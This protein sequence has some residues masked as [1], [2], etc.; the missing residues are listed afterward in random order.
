[1]KIAFVAVSLML[2]SVAFG[3]GKTQDDIK[4]KQRKDIKSSSAP[5]TRA[6][7]VVVFEKTWKSLVT[8]L[9]VKGPNPVRLANDSA[10]ISKNEILASLKSIVTK[11]QPMFKR[12][13]SPVT[14]TSGRLRKDFDRAN[15]LK[16]IKDGFVMPV[17]PLVV[18]KNGPVST[19][20]FGDSVGVLLIRISD[21]VH[22]PSRQFS[23]DLMGGKGG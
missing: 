5:V 4:M 21:L 14:F 11:V 9:K 7:A 3:Q 20:E 8:G 18:G 1:M 13:A 16:L 12:S 15:F 6:E 17:G 10:P 22:M 2:G 19:Y 23:P